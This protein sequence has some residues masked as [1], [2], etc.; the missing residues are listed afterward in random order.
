MLGIER[1]ERARTCAEVSL[2]VLALKLR[3]TCPWQE[4]LRLVVTIE[5][6]HHRDK[7][8][9]DILDTKQC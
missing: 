9:I 3:C 2:R 7:N 1:R 5:N 8:R 6:S 4:Y